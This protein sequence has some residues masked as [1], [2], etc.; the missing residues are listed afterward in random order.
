MVNGCSHN[1][2]EKLI[3]QLSGKKARKQ[4]DN[5]KIRSNQDQNIKFIKE[6]ELK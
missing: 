4:Q 3:M 2:P 1:S 5:Q 6:Y